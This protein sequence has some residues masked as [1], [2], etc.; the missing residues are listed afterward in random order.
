[1]ILADFIIPMLSNSYK[2]APAPPASIRHIIH[3]I[4]IRHNTVCAYVIV[5]TAE[6]P[7]AWH[8]SMVA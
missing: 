7:L 3:I 2:H 1:M 5:V 4:H 6:P 8:E